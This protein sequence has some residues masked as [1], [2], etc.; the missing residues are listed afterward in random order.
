ME[1]L[2]GQKTHDKIWDQACQLYDDGDVKAL[3]HTLQD[4]Y[5]CDVNIMLILAVLES[6]GMVP[7]NDSLTDLIEVSDEWQEEIL[8]PIRRGRLDLKPFKAG[9][10]LYDIVKGMELIVEREEYNNLFEKLHLVP[11][12]RQLRSQIEPY[13]LRRAG[14]NK[15]IPD[16]SAF[17]KA[18]RSVRLA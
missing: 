18:S 11:A 14:D 10:G 12:S 9:Q 6:I 17:E 4:D 7:T 15:P 5:N 13:I 3:C 1:F 16:L 2:R 8:R